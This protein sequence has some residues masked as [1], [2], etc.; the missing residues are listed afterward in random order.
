MNTNPTVY[1][2]LFV[3]QYVTTVHLWP[4]VRLQLMIS[5]SCDNCQKSNSFGWSKVKFSTGSE[6]SCAT[7]PWPS[8]SFIATSAP[9]CKAHLKCCFHIAFALLAQITFYTWLQ[10]VAVGFLVQLSEKPSLGAAMNSHITAILWRQLFSTQQWKNNKIKDKRNY[11]NPNTNNQQ[12]YSQC[13]TGQPAHH[14]TLNVP[15]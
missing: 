4:I 6:I 1:A 5:L 13:C 9:C 11:Q 15:S 10:F 8:T 14:K 2:V 12:I 7:T 3:L